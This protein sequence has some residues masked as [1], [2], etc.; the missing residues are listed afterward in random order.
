MFWRDPRCPDANYVVVDTY[1]I[2]EDQ[3]AGTVCALDDASK[4]GYDRF[5]QV[6]MDKN[7]V[8]LTV[9]CHLEC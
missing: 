1:L 9:V 4:R 5:A 2:V 8:A 7:L 6:P 3:A